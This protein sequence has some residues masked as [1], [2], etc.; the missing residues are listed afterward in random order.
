[1][2]VD[3]S[4]KA[5]TYELCHRIVKL[6]NYTSSLKSDLDEAVDCSAKENHKLEK[7]L[8]EK[9]E[10]IKNLICECKALTRPLSGLRSCD[11]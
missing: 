3:E 5:E 7:L 9:K 11:T 8:E 10:E 4:M 6:E 1:M 2:D